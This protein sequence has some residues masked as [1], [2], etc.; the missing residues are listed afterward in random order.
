MARIHPIQ[1][2]VGNEIAS[3]FVGDDESGNTLLALLGS[4]SL[5]PQDTLIETLLLHHD[6]SHLRVAWLINAP[7]NSIHEGT[8]MFGFNVAGVGT[9]REA[10]TM[11]QTVSDN[12]PGS[13]LIT[14]PLQNTSSCDT[15]DV[16]LLPQRGK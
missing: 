2:I 3:I 4:G 6:G 10:A 13:I 11:F 14:D 7:G 16:R 5:P 15:I 12:Y 9:Y 1:E 8:L